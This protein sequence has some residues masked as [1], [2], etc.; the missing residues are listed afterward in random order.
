VKKWATCVLGLLFVS[1]VVVTHAQWLTLTLPDT[2]RNADGTVNLSAPTPRTAEGKPDCSGIWLLSRTFVAKALARGRAAGHPDG[3]Q[4]MWWMM[5]ENA[6]IP[7]RPPMAALY[8]E[9]VAQLGA[10]S[11]ASRCLPQGIPDAMILTHMKIVQSRQ[12]T[13]ILFEAFNHFRQVFT[14]GR[15]LPS[16]DWQPTWFGYSLCRWDDDVFVTQTAAF[17]DQSWMDFAGL[18]H[19][20]ALRTTERFRRRDF[21]HLDVNITFEDA[22]AYTRPWSIDLPFDLQADTELL[23]SVCDNERDSAHMVTK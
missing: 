11:P 1:A 23:E 18:P 3:P 20:D 16:I 7:L 2:P 13:V 12:L 5:P 9:R 21:G 10:R 19:S 17:N 22:K 15:S 4:Q 6:E 8:R 14:D